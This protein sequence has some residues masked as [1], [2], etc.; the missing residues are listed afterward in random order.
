MAGIVVNALTLQHRRHPSP[1]FASRPPAAIAELKSEPIAAPPLPP[2]PAEAPEIAA[3]PPSPPARPARLGAA[4]EPTTSTRASDPIA[5]MLRARA[6]KD[7]QK[8]TAAAQASLVKLGYAVKVGGVANA[9]TLAAIRDFEKSHNLPIAT[10]I[11]SRLVHTLSA[12][13]ASAAS[14]SR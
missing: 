12:A 8:L 2:P 11:T 4:A 9:E 13:A 6:A 1:F 14:A 7:P 10:E 3:S 5:D